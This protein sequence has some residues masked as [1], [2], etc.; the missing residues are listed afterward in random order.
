M[1]E[2]RLSRM[3]EALQRASLDALV[4]NPGPTMAYAS[5]LS[6]HLMERP[7]IFVVP[8]EGRPALILPEFER[9]KGEASPLK[10]TLFTYAEDP[11]ARAATF[12]AAASQLGLPGRR[13]GVEP[14]RMRVF[15]L[16]LLEAAA[17]G[18][19]F[20]S[21]EEVI[22]AVR[23]AKDEA[24]VNSMRHAVCA[25]EAA[26]Q[27]TIPLLNPG[28][29]E[30]EAASELTVQ[31]LRAGSDSELPFPPIVASGP[32][33]ALPHAVPTDRRLQ[34]GDMLVIDWGA[35]VE[36]YISDL[37]RTLA[38]EPVDPELARVHAIGLEATRAGR[39]AVRPGVACAEVDRAA[40]QV[41]EAA[42][43]GEFFTHRTGHG[44]GMEAHEP[45]Y[46]RGDNAETLVPGM[47]F[48]V[49]PG[50]YL[51]GRGGVRIEDN[52]VV[53]PQ[54]CECLSSAPRELRGVA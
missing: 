11:A 6:F 50:I 21:A 54:G 17:P 19:Q 27:A 53:T 46:I 38:F 32:N 33:S 36:G 49:E 37:T 22:T 30:R 23:V 31:L 29:T 26:L 40:R 39:A 3:Q 28:M 48:T 13:V 18:T 16:R 4:L 41:I 45:P 34:A 8:P 9:T 43:Y 44:I 47:T 52:V 7:V 14:L 1:L 2:R 12:E 35:T 25:A 10:P 24:E 20:L 51:P 5:G 15:E 42:G